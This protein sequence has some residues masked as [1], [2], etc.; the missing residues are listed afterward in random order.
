MSSCKLAVLLVLLGVASYAAENDIPA[1]CKSASVTAVS[2]AGAGAEEGAAEGAA[3]GAEEGD[4]LL[5]HPDDC[6]LFYYCDGAG[7]PVCRQCPAGLH[8]SPD[9]HV[10]DQ[11]D[12]AGCQ[13]ATTTA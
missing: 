3:E 12:H 11:P 9:S 6:R 4:A 13:L 2:C 7:A 10:C 1:L 8:F 5:A